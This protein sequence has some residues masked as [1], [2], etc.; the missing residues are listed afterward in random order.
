MWGIVMGDNAKEELAENRDLQMYY[1]KSNQLINAKG[2]SSALNLKLFAIAI[3]A[4][5]IN[6]SD[7]QIVAVIP[8]MTLRRIL[9]SNSN[10]FYDQIKAVIKPVSPST[11][12]LLD[13]RLYLEDD[14]SQH[15]EG[16]NIVTHATFV[17]GTLTIVLNKELES[18]LFHLKSNYTILSLT[19]VVKL[20]SAYSIKLYEIFKSRMDRE[21]AT[22]R[23]AGPY[24]ISYDLDELKQELGIEDPSV[25]VTEIRKKKSGPTHRRDIY[26]EYSEF[27]RRVLDKAKEELNQCTSVFMEY[28]PVRSGK[29]GRVVAVEFTLTRQAP[30]EEVPAAGAPAKT[31]SENDRMEVMDL[32]LGLI[33][34]KI[35]LRDVKAICE[36]ADYDEGR[37]R[38]AIDASRRTGRIE[39]LTGW[40]ISAIRNG[41]EAPEKS[42]EK[43]NR[44]S[45]NRFNRYPQNSYDFEALEK[46]LMEQQP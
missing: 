4:A 24:L 19:D 41:Y 11:P 42:S 23:N 31:L 29:G 18:Q 7:G 8:G 39:N 34:G 22:T 30:Q 16:I 45:A 36:A 44:S 35:S 40:L 28:R 15:I 9:G 38:K 14:A 1:S 3:R 33:P 25:P 21:M 10:S 12:S 6:P 32:V 20:K 46:F 2:R 17:N 37:I 13:W 5:R 43:E 26:A 27:R